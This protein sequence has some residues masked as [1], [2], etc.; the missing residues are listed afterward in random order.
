MKRNTLIALAATTLFAAS[1]LIA[2]AKP[3]H[4]DKGWEDQGPNR[5]EVHK[6]Y[7]KEDIKIMAEARALRLMGPGANVTVKATDRGTFMVDVVDPSG[8]LVHEDEVSVYGFPIHGVG[9]GPEHHHRHHDED[10][11]KG[12][13]DNT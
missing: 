3:D 11:D 13:R 4:H 2:Q 6:P 9:P 1:P 5:C 12:D 7:T 8:H 10:H